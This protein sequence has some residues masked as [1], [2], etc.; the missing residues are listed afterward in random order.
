MSLSSEAPN[1]HPAFEE[2]KIS[3]KA[4][5]ENTGPV[6]S[7]MEELA[8]DSSE[9][10]LFVGG[11]DDKVTGEQLKVY[12]SKYGQIQEVNIIVDWVTGKSKRCALV[13]CSDPETANSILSFK[14]HLVHRRRVRVSRADVNKRGTKIIKA[15]ILHLSQIHPSI[16]L[17]ELEQYLSSF[18]S[19][20]KLRLTPVSNPDDLSQTRHGYLELAKE[21]DCQNILEN[22]RTLAINDFKFTCTPFRVRTAQESNL[23]SLIGKAPDSQLLRYFELYEMTSQEADFE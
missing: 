2:N 18:G 23:V 5:A 17:P 8:S 19:V 11:L 14:K 13:F 3:P 10:I 16:T 20:K 1:D 7:E 22:R 4:P 9:T 6:G 12:F 15:R 21:E